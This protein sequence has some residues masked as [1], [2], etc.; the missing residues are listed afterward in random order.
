[1]GDKGEYDVFKHSPLRYLGYVNEFGESF[2]PFIPN[3]VVVGTYVVATSYAIGDAIHKG[4]MAY[5][6][7]ST[8]RNWIVADKVQDT[9]IW[10]LLAS[11]T[12][13][14]YIINRTVHAT[15]WAL[16]KFVC[17]NHSFRARGIFKFIPTL[18]GLATIPILPH[19]LDPLIDEAMDHTTR[20]LFKTLQDKYA[21]EIPPSDPLK[22]KSII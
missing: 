20:P 4:Q 22:N 7:K 18:V 9:L 14:A 5:T 8:M 6:K 1:M 13:P 2:R 10:Q 12:I 17:Q 21:S 19:V 11:V 15:N 3:S 16:T